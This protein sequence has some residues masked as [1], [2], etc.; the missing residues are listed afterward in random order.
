MKL[1]AYTL[2]YGWAGALLILGG[3]GI[4]TGRWELQQFFHLDFS[5][6]SDSARGTFLNQYRFL[7]SI[8]FGFGLFCFVFRREIFSVRLFNRLFLT[9]VFAGV[10]ARLLSMVVDAWPHVA[11]VS[12]TALEI[13]TGV[14]ILIY[15]RTT[16]ER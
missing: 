12:V 4:V 3:A 11:M 5:A 14:V 13:A 16:V 15:T 6:M 10:A 8:E 7:K 2:F 9:I 1:L